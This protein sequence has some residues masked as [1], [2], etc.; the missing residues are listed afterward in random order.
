VKEGAGAVSG[1]FNTKFPN[2]RVLAFGPHGNLVVLGGSQGWL[3]VC[4]WDGGTL[5]EKAILREHQPVNQVVFPDGKTFVAVGN[6]PAVTFWNAQSLK[7][8]KTWTN[9]HTP[10]HSAAFSADG[11][12]LVIGVPQNQVLAARLAPYDL[13]PLKA[14][15]E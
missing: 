7:L 12:H 1:S 11:R 4:V 6:N 9:L 2:Q 14:A 15:L 3:H 10:G 5:A 13:E 8:Q